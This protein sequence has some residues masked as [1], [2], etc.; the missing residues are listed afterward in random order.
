MS[1]FNEYKGQKPAWETELSNLVEGTPTVLR[2]AVVVL[3][4]VIT[5]YSIHYTKLYE[6]ALRR[7]Q[8]AGTHTG[9]RSFGRPVVRDLRDAGRTG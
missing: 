2:G 1:T 7:I 5:S 9:L 6:H 8:A 3:A 4:S